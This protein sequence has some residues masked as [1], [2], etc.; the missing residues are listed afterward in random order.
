MM[1][2][3][4]TQPL[5]TAYHDGGWGHREKT[6]ANEPGSVFCVCWCLCSYG[7]LQKYSLNEM[8]QYFFSRTELIG[9]PN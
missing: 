1:N 4:V 3:A 5:S 9:T 7:T 8:K 6:V 2:R